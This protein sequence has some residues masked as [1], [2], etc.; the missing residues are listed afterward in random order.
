MGNHCSEQ[1]PGEKLVRQKPNHNTESLHGLRGKRHTKRAS[2]R[3]TGK[4]GDAG[5]IQHNI[6]GLVSGSSQGVPGA[7][8]G[9]SHIK[10][11]VRNEWPGAAQQTK[12]NY[13]ILQEARHRDSKWGNVLSVLLMWIIKAAGALRLILNR[14]GNERQGIMLAHWAENLLTQCYKY[15]TPNNSWGI[16]LFTLYLNLMSF[17]ND[18]KNAWKLVFIHHGLIRNIN[19]SDF[20]KNSCTRPS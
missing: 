5:R 10:H 7:V 3:R 17:R 8:A 1:Q 2:E 16:F 13:C 4:W 14:P 15:Q 19:N 11:A 6:R 20:V 9:G 12:R 18:H